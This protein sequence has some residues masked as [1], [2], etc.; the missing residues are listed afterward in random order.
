MWERCHRSSRGRLRGR[1]GGMADAS[2]PAV[3]DAARDGLFAAWEQTITST[4]WDIQGINF[5]APPPPVAT[6]P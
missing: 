4:G 5:P 6:L 2:P 3:P 1:Q